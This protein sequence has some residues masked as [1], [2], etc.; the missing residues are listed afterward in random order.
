MAVVVGQGW[1]GAGRGEGRCLLS[2]GQG[3]LIR[4]Y[5]LHGPCKNICLIPSNMDLCACTVRIS[6]HARASTCTHSSARACVLRHAPQDSRAAT[7]AGVRQG[8][9]D[10]QHASMALMRAHGCYW[11]PT[12]QIPQFQ[13]S[14]AVTAEEATSLVMRA[15]ISSVTSAGARC[16]VHFCSACALSPLV[17]YALCN[18]HPAASEELSGVKAAHCTAARWPRSTNSGSGGGGGADMY[19]MVCGRMLTEVHGLKRGR[20]HD[21]GIHRVNAKLLDAVACWSRWCCGLSGRGGS[22]ASQ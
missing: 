11:S 15:G 8:T 20:W 9:C 14:F 5:G 13:C 17:M 10:L 21:R 6:I 2:G 18:T 22:S 1:G 7:A 12:A 3:W 4:P 16:A 19:G